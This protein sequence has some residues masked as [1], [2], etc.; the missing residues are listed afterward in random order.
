MNI[1]PRDT[2]TQL[3]HF[4][5]RG[6]SL[7]GRAPSTISALSRGDA[8]VARGLTEITRSMADNF[9]ENIFWDLEVIADALRGGVPADLLARVQP[10]YGQNGEIRFRY[11]HDFIY[12][13]D[14]AK[15]VR[16]APT[17]RATH[18]PFSEAFLAYSFRRGHEL[19]ALIADNDSKYGQLQDARARNPFG[20]SREPD[21]EALLFR[22]L[23]ERDLLPVRAWDTSARP[24]WDRPFAELRTERAGALGLAKP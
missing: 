3:D 22:D 12:G 18:G 23:A 21:D 8:Q 1:E 6:L 19:L 16:R 13:F 10:L 15:W 7:S 2:L 5:S 9:P 4:I 24:V 20:F 11:I 14:W 17:E